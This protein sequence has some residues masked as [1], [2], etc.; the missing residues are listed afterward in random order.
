MSA[1]GALAFATQIVDTCNLSGHIVLNDNTAFICKEERQFKIAEGTQIE[2][3]SHSVLI[4]SSNVISFGEDNPNKNIAKLSDG[5][6]GVNISAGRGQVHIIAATAT[7]RLRAEGQ[8]ISMSYLSVS[9]YKHLLKLPPGFSAVM[10]LNE[11]S[12]SATDSRLIWNEQ[13]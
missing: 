13:F 9:N 4:V 2:T 6:V 1:P 12:F 8:V 11:S 10:Q 3:Q 7:G 5:K